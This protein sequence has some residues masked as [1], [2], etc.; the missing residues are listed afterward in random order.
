MNGARS[1]HVFSGLSLFFLFPS[2]PPRPSSAPRLP[3]ALRMERTET[4][5]AATER[6]KAAFFSVNLLSPDEKVK[7]RERR[8]NISRTE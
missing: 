4:K 3:A 2:T 8:R 1:F 7:G 6:E 5:A